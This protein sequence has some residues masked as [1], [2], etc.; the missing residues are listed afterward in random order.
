[1]DRRVWIS[2]GVMAMV[3]VLASWWMLGAG[4]HSNPEVGE[5]HTVRESA[6][7]NATDPAAPNRAMTRVSAGSGGFG[8]PA[9]NVRDALRDAL[10]QRGAEDFVV[11]DMFAMAMFACM[12]VRAAHHPARNDPRRKWALDYLD[13]ACAG[14][15][16][17][18]FRAIE[19]QPPITALLEAKFAGDT[20][21]ADA[22][23][24]RDLESAQS[25]SELGLANAHLFK[26]R[27]LPFPSPDVDE[28][29][30]IA[31]FEF[32]S[33]PVTCAAM[34]VCGS[35]SV[36]AA[37]LCVQDGCPPGTTG[38]QAMRRRLSPR[39]YEAALRMRAD[40]LAWRTRAGR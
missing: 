35:E 10:A 19:A 15:D 33:I 32:A 13:R 34:Q 27:A 11:R 23:A 6:T 31:A 37:M 26:Q 17:A 7:A 2:G 4:S 36:W 8:G 9:P 30:Q 5:P 1:M 16:P 29:E 22:R 40:W 24:L 39:E 20:E 3:V 38:E 18:E 21:A 25:P 28:F 12:P 14:F